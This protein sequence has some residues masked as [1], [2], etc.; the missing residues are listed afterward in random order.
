MA[1]ASWGGKVIAES[2]KSVVVEGNP[3]FPA[4]SVNKEFLRPSEYTSECPW[5]GTAHYYHLE[6]M[7]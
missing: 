5:K 3:Y 6:G 2:D 4:E 1:R 7:G